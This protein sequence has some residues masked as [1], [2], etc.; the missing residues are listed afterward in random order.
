MVKKPRFSSFMKKD[1]P[2]LEEKKV[3]T[4]TGGLFI[5]RQKEQALKPAKSEL[6]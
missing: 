3:P 6:D 1:R 4:Q 2:K 5:R